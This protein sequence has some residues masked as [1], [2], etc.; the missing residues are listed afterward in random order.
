MD[1]GYTAF[2]TNIVFPGYPATAISQGR[3]GPQ[4]DQLAEYDLIQHAVTQI[5]KMREAVG[6]GIGI[7]L[8]INYNFK[9]QGAIA[10]ARA[11]EPYKLFWLEIDNQ[12]PRAL[13]QLKDST[14]IPITS[15]EQLQT[16][17]QYYPFFEQHAMDTV[18]VDVQWQ[19]FSAAKK[20]A[21]LAEMFEINIAPHNYNGHLSTF[22]SLNL[23]AAVSNVR[24]MESDPDAP[25]WRDELFTEVPQVEKSYIPIP[26]KPGWGTEL[27]ESAARKHAYNK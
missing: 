10:I 25:P 13:R 22:Q 4:H 3:S 19:G 18:K 14:T 5:A 20:V 7:C 21:D 6:P 11:L 1:K 17:R 12:D 2:K 9:T 26:T 23:T 8:D 27:D 24:I 16:M 15:G